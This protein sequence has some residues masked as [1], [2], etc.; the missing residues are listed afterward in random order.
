M[1]QVW[2]IN[3]A[4]G[5]VGTGDLEAAIGKRLELLDRTKKAWSTR[6]A[7]SA[8]EVQPSRGDVAVLIG[9]DVPSPALASP[10]LWERFEA[11]IPVVDDASQVGS[12]IPECLHAVN[13]LVTARYGTYWHEVAADAVVARAVLLRTGRSVFIS[14]KR[15]ESLTVARQLSARLAEDGFDVF[16]DEQSIDHGVTFASEIVYR[17]SDVDMLVV[18]ATPGLQSSVW[19]SAELRLAERLKISTVAVKFPSPVPTPL[20]DTLM[21]D[22]IFESSAPPRNELSG[23]DLENL[24]ALLYEQR[25]AAIA[26]RVH[27]VI[28]PAV[29][30]LR[31]RHPSNGIEFGE[32]LGELVSRDEA[33]REKVTEVVAAAPFRPTPTSLWRTRS[34]WPD[35]PTVRY[36]YQEDAPSDPRVLALT[37]GMRPHRPAVEVDNV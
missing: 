14:Y 18:L 11:V 24:V 5:S 32:R 3:E 15:S 23:T 21:A 25:V 6:V 9:R 34:R 19:V 16:L 1:F 2:I 17:L 10:G 37:W 31:A 13:A 33:D 12:F 30:A 4:R 20:T 27:D 35:V 29:A 28:P 7:T 36:V 22:Q 8:A 26:R